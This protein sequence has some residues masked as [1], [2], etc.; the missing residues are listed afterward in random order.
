MITVVA[1]VGLLAAVPAFA[2]ESFYEEVLP[3]DLEQ[4]GEGV[5]PDAEQAPAP[6]TRG[7]RPAS[8]RGDSAGVDATDRGVSV[9]GQR[10]VVVAG[11]QLPVTG[12]GLAAGLVLGLGLIGGG[13]A[14]LTVAR[15]RGR[16]EPPLPA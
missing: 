15:R 7:E 5:A 8:A 3:G 2:Q 14:A 9:A 6:A 1:L 4:P 11:R 12:F 10:G 16:A 13:A